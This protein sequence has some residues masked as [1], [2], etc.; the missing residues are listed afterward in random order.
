MDTNT[1][2]EPS[3]LATRREWLGLAVLALPTLL[4]AL[5]M[6]VLYLA[7]PHLSAELGATSTEQLWITDIYGFMIAG[8][9]VTMGTLGDRIGRRKLMLIGAVAFAG[10]SVLAAY[11]T[12]PEMLIIARA[13][14]GVAG[15]TLMPSTLA[16]ITNM[17]RDPKQMGVAI[18]VWM[19]CFMGGLAVGPV[20]GGA[21]L[22]AF[23]WGTAFLLGVP[24]MALLLIAGPIYLPEH[25]DPEAG[26]LDP[27]S[28]LLSL[29]ALLPFVYSLK[30]LARSGW[31]TT[32][33][34]AGIVGIV[35]GVVFVLRQRRLTSPLL[36]VT[37]FRN[38]AFSAALGIFI[39]GGLVAGSF[40]LIT[41][42]L[43]TVEGLSPLSAGLW[44]LPATV[45]T[46]FGVMAA[47]MLTKTIRPAYVIAGGL[48]LTA[49]GYALISQVEATGGL[50]LVVIG[51]VVA[52]L[53]VGP[54]SALTTGLVLGSAPPEKA[55]SASSVSETS[56]ELGIALGIAVLGSV[57]TAVYTAQAT[58][59]L[60][61]GLPADAA[62]TASE[63]IA[64]ATNVAT[65]LGGQLGADVLTAAR[66][67]FAT[68][69]NTSTW[70]SA[71][72]AVVM[73]LLALVALRHE[74]ATGA[75]A[76]EEPAEA[77]EAAAVEA[78]DE[79]DKRTD[80]VSPVA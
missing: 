7:L 21:L 49:L 72:L 62:A 12:S 43:Q 51:L 1:G 3:V 78:T 11:S 59:N 30:E 13:L 52:N 23:S 47:P 4:L 36:D 18:G 76:A 73:A 16:L 9:L 19:S 80:S 57:G 61:S 41:L 22:Q 31:A 71:G 2:G 35:F 28:V 14:M 39:L 74:P 45:G 27:V 6:S 75:A 63:S 50:T 55:G 64:G 67:S 29:L 44:L 10:A 38:R 25:R 69:L 58:D 66:E 77:P 53:G 79:D 24:V 70:I 60:P 40:L 54:M 15:A 32:T 26:K 17:F 37:L 20:V 42:Y 48:T 5:D 56:G 34:L 8:F 46:I 65:Q 68:A 33:V